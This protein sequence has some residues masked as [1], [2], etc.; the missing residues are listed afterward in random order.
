VQVQQQQ[1]N[2]MVNYV[3]VQQQQ[4]NTVQWQ[5]PKTNYVKCNVDAA[6]FAEQHSFGIG[7]CIRNHRGHFIKAAT[8][9]HDANP[10][11]QEAEAISLHDA[12]ICLRQLGI[13]NV[14]FELDR[15][16]VVDIIVDRT[17]NQVEFGNIIS[18]CKSLPSQSPNISFVRRRA[19]SVAHS[20]TKVSRMHARHQ[21]FDLI[22][23]CID[24]IVRNEIMSFCL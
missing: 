19:N 16:L 3:Q 6:L 17:N 1:I 5:P 20:L 10:P 4:I 8:T 7:M 13:S 23:S 2:T 14:H 18:I 15:K 12:I 24:S 21:I 11:P 9:W 22:P